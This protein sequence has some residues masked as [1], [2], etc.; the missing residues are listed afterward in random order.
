[1]TFVLSGE[2]SSDLGTNNVDGTLKKGAM[3]F[4]LDRLCKINIDDEPDY[5]LLTEGDVKR[6][7]KANLRDISPRGFAD[8]SD[9]EPLW[10]NSFCLAAFAKAKGDGVGLVYFKDSDG[11]NTAPHD[12]WQKMVAAM[13]SGFKHAEYK[14][15][16][17]MVPRPKSEAWFLAYYQ[18]ND[19][20]HHAYDQCAR[21][22]EMPGN[23]AIPNSC[24]V[25]L[26]TLCACRGDV[27][28]EVIT[29]D[30]VKAID[31]NR[32]DM[33]S[34]VSFKK[35]FEN[36]LAGLTRRPYP[37]RDCRHTVPITE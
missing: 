6:L 25:L 26:K 22:E 3:T 8:R 14:C 34:F 23:D 12:R 15:G 24:K 35:R 10:L 19:G 21:F 1:M 2:G 5:D 33:P 18:K 29:E 11:T 37:H 31:W 32:V 7:R 13:Y 20:A 9:S 4:I 28:A 16:V 36:V 17:A 27:Y 30:A